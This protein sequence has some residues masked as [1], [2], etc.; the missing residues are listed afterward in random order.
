MF[1]NVEKTC[2]VFNLEAIGLSL[3]QPDKK[4]KPLKSVC[5]HVTLPNKHFLKYKREVTAA[6]FPSFFCFPF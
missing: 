6:V 2:R 4:P 3:V 5:S 1:R